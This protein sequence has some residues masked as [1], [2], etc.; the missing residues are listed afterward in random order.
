MLSVMYVFRGGDLDATLFFLCTRISVFY[1]EKLALITL[2]P[3]SGIKSQM[4]A[5]EDQ[6]LYEVKSAGKSLEWANKGMEMD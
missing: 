2:I 4:Q 5:C 3:L 1:A 6:S